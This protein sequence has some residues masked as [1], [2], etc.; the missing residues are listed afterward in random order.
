MS[1][2]TLYIYDKRD[3]ELKPQT[4]TD[5]NNETLLPTVKFYFMVS[6]VTVA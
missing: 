4:L 1:F 6:N 3:I 2:D 5:F